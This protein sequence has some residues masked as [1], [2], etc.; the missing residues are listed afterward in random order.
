NPHSPIT[1]AQFAEIH[2]HFGQKPVLLP[3]G[4]ADK[5]AVTTYI[6]DLEKARDILQEALGLDADNV[7]NW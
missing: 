2:V 5:T 3:F 7:A 1:D 6:A 4:S